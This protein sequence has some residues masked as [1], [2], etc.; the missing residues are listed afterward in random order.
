MT[1]RRILPLLLLSA[2]LVA[3]AGCRGKT[4]ASQKKKAAPAI[5]VQVLRVEPATISRRL[6]YD[7]D[8]QGETELR[9]FAQVAERIVSLAVEEGDRVKQGQTLATLRAESL[10]EGV[11]SAA[12]AVD[13]A[14]ADRDNLKSELERSERLLA[15][16]IVSKAQVDTLRARLLSAEA[17]IRRLEAM[18][19]QASTARSYT[20]IRSP[21]TGVVGRRYLSQGDLA[22]PALPILTVVKMERVE[23]LVEVPEQDLAQV[24]LGMPARL[25]VARYPGRAFEGKVTLIAPMIDRQTRMARVKVGVE[26]KDAALMPGMLAKVSL[27]VERRDG[28]LVVPYG[29]VVIESD[30]EG[31][32]SY[33][34][35]VVEG[36]RARER[37]LTLGLIDGNR[38][39]ITGGLTA[40]ELMVVKGGHL[41]ETGK[42]V[43]VAETVS[44]PPPS[45]G[46]GDAPPAT[47]AGPKKVGSR[48]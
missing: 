44:L 17:Q 8:V 9:V 12:A 1:S 30:K 20:V 48:P 34:A 2:L 14:R 23:L 27:E 43:E 32:V 46:T 38:V 26:N 40:G 7:A 16:N 18:T 11:R 35:F 41:L 28:V 29:G 25:A 15:K 42:L 3:S 19:S 37:A 24:R 31:K 45:D 36:N 10:S 47:G 6:S 33:R 21:L 13:A 4:D 22:T 5:P 39:E